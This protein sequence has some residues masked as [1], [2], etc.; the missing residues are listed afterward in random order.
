MR[1]KNDHVCV[2]DLYGFVRVCVFVGECRIDHIDGFYCTLLFTIFCVYGFLGKSECCTETHS[3]HTHHTWRDANTSGVNQIED[4]RAEEKEKNHHRWISMLESGGCPLNRNA[5][6]IAVVIYND[7]ISTENAPSAFGSR[8][9]SVRTWMQCDS[10]CVI[11]IRSI[12]MAPLSETRAHDTHETTKFTP[13]K[14]NGTGM[15]ATQIVTEWI[16]NEALRWI[17]K[18]HTARA[19]SSNFMFYLN[20]LVVAI[21]F[22]FYDVFWSFRS[23][24]SLWCKYNWFRKKSPHTHI[25]PHRHMI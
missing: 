2:C 24:P 10:N 21:C 20:I 25:S 4:V 19:H 6:E 5:R 13:M 7:E 1:S 11:T 23:I 12:F 9:H 16:R 8:T 18:L 14:C 22:H 3:C 15:T 17:Q